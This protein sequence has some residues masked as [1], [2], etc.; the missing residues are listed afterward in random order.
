M[1]A[2]LATAFLLA[3]T[4]A[5]TAQPAD[6]PNRGRTRDNID[7]YGL[8]AHEV[9]RYAREYYPGIRACYFDHGRASKTATGELA[10]K[11][12][13]HRNGNVHEVTLDAPGVRGM[14]LRKLEGCVRLQVVG[15]GFP[16][17]RDFTTVVLPYYFMYLA[18][19]GA[20][21]QYSCWNPRGCLTK[22]AKA[23]R[24]E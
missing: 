10:I 24:R 18:P 20:G 23:R 3:A 4:T 17:R 15:W 14:H 5:A 13:I 22:G 9:E 1:R 12:V 6:N 16:V 19:P 8:T 2:T 21:P 11:V 7:E